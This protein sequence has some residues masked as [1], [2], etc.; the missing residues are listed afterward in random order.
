MS[1]NISFED[2]DELTNTYNDHEIAKLLGSNYCS[3]ATLRASYG[4]KT[5]TQKTGLIKIA[6]TGEVRKKGSVRGA[7]R[8]DGLKEDYF[9]LIDTPEKAYWL[10]LLFADGWVSF[11]KGQPKELGLALKVADKNHVVTF[12]NAV[13]YSGKIVEHINRN[14]LKAGGVSVLAT[15]RITAQRFTANA[16]QA[17]I[18]PN[19]SGNLKLTDST[20]VYPSSFV[21]GYFDGDGSLCDRNFTFICNSVEYAE[22]LQTLIKD[23]TGHTLYLAYAESPTSKKQVARLSGYRKNK[24]V[25]HWMYSD[26]NPYL[27][28]KYETFL[29]YWS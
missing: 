4:V 20:K 25:L 14:T 16:I 8:T 27:Q 13:G 2:L 17:G 26:P 9:C 21:R 23:A 7:V 19:K 22:E 6:A 18:T 29:T 5:F 24:D 12:K 15:V 11:R 10:G 28:R 3:V 1:L